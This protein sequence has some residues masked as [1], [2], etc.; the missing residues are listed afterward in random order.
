MASSAKR[1]ASGGSSNFN[2]WTRAV[3]LARSGDVEP[4][5]WPFGV[6]ALAPKAHSETMSIALSGLSED[7]RC[8]HDA[9]PIQA[10][11]HETPVLAT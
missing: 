7:F 10:A 2:R 1:K 5:G 8:S 3:F 9:Q 4:G 11:P 6:V